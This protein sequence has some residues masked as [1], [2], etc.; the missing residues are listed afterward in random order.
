[1]P[2]RE[3]KNCGYSEKT[4][5]WTDADWLT[6]VC[7]QVSRILVG[8]VLVLVPSP[9]LDHSYQ[10]QL[11]WFWCPGVNSWFQYLVPRGFGAI[12]LLVIWYLCRLQEK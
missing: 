2:E 7:E 11:G 4:S 8:L 1:M 12:I 6:M 5:I 9:V 3:G 10:Y